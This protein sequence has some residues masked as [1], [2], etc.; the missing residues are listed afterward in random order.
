MGAAI[1]VAVAPATTRNGASVALNG[2]IVGAAVGQSSRNVLEMGNSNAV[3]MAPT[4]MNR[5][6]P[7]RTR[8]M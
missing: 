3:A 6:G 5:V 1:L 4:Q 8:A 7:V 2:S